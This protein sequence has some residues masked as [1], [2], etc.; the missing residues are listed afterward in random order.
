MFRR[1]HLVL[2]KKNLQQWRIPHCPSKL[3][4][5]LQLVSQKLLGFALRKKY[6]KVLASV[7]I[8]QKNYRA[9]FWKK[10]LQRLKASAIVLQKHWR[11]QLA[12]S[13]H[14][15]LLQQEQRRK[16]E[17]EERRRQEEEERIRRE[18]EE[19]QWQEEEELKRKQE[20][21][22]EKER[23]TMVPCMTLLR[24]MGGAWR[25]SIALRLWGNNCTS[26][27]LV[28]ACAGLHRAGLELGAGVEKLGEMEH[29]SSLGR[30]RPPG[31]FPL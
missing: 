13:L 15:H 23:Y 20:E 21:E 27:I 16:Q 8:I 3:F 19:R 9:H 4:P 1:K 18:E 24:H 10:A 2:I 29:S 22:E 31:V 26:L 28:S 7:V 6:R 12:R 17:V 11:G 30:V 25:D 14:R 5:W